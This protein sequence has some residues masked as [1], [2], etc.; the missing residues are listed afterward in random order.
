MVAMPES[1]RRPRPDPAAE[2]ALMLRAILGPSS[3][4]RS[5]PSNAQDVALLRRLQGA[6]ATLE[7]L[8]GTSG[9]SES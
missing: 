4:A 8:G 9:R 1:G 6:L 3:E 2:A 7:T 5:K